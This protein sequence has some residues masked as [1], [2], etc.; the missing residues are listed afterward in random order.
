MVGPKLARPFVLPMASIH[1]SNGSLIRVEVLNGRIARL[2][3]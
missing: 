2:A 3:G 1:L